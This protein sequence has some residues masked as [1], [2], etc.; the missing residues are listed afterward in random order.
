MIYC[1]RLKPL[2]FSLKQYE[3]GFNLL[4]NWIIISRTLRQT[5]DGVNDLFCIFHF[6]KR[7]STLNLIMLFALC[8]MRSAYLTNL[9]IQ[10]III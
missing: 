10:P 8:T 3:S 6:E 5:P 2:T 7:V 4:K 1:L 9:C